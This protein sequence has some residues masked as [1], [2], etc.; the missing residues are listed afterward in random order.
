[1]GLVRDHMCDS[2]RCH[3]RPVLVSGAA[4]TKSE[5]DRVV[6]VRFK[7]PTCA[8]VMLRKGDRLWCPKCR[9]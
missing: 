3:P 1:M 5:A 9:I 7:C 2:S 6:L 4:M 8:T